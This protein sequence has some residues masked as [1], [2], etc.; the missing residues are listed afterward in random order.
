MFLSTQEHSSASVLTVLWREMLPKERLKATF[1][2]GAGTVVNDA[3][4]W[5]VRWR[6]ALDAASSFDSRVKEF[7]TMEPSMN[8]DGSR[9]IRC[10]SV[11]SGE[12]VTGL[13]HGSRCE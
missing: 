9:R 7:H 4:Q 5:R 13:R 1:T 8:H 6:L 12:Q 2:Y 11:P 10:H 3:Q